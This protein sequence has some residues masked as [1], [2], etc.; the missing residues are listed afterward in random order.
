MNFAGIV[1]AGLFQIN[2]VVPN[3]GN[4]DQLLRA[5]VGGVATPNNV[6]LTFFNLFLTP[7]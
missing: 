7:Q 3:V 6:F 1:E 5:T 2:V 4:G